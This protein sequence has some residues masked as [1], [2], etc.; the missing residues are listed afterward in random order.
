M[1]MLSDFMNENGIKPEDVVNQS[2]AMEQRHV[3]DR[4]VNAK[5]AQARAAKKTY[6]ELNLEKTKPLGRGVSALALNRAIA[7][8]PQPRLVRKKIARAVNAVLVVKKKEP[9]EWRKLFADVKSAKKPKK[10]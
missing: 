8:T 7:G 10:K 1:T 5:R 4:A 3:D 9:V 2:R 6:A